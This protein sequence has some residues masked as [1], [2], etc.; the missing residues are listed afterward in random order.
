MTFGIT[1]AIL[2]LTIFLIRWRGFD[3]RARGSHALEVL[4][5]V[6]HSH[7]KP[8]MVRRLA[9]GRVHPVVS[10]NR[11]QPYGG[12]A[13][14]NLTVHGAPGRI[15]LNTTRGELEDLNEKVE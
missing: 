12:V 13:R 14:S 7:H 5:Y 6:G 1:H 4:I 9:M 3:L 11:M 8:A 10:G 15:A 2:S